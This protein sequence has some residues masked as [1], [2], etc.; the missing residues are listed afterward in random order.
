MTPPPKE[1]EG[2]SII[3]IRSRLAHANNNPGNL[4]YVPSQLNA[5]PGEGGFAHFDTPEDGLKALIRQIKLDQSRGY[6]LEEFI[7]KYAP[8]IE[9]NTGHYIEYMTKVTG[10]A[11][12]TRIIFIPVSN[13]VRAIMFIESGTIVN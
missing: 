1:E 12:D 4:R 3:T 5:Q 13:L 7:H 11:Q 8:P 10:A 9:N 2:K 6:T